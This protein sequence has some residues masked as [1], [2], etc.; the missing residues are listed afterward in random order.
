MNN[1]AN[2]TATRQSWT[3]AGKPETFLYFGCDDECG[4]VG[5]LAKMVKLPESRGRVLPVSVETGENLYPF[6]AI[7]MATGS[8]I[9]IG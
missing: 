7:G 5:V 4:A 8:K 6:P 9:W 2:A 3:K 1:E